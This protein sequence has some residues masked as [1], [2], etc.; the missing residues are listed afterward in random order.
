MTAENVDLRTLR[1]LQAPVLST[2]LKMAAPNL[3][4][5]L[6]QN[7]V[8][9][10]ELH[11]IGQ[12]GSE[13]LAGV[14]LVLP[15][16]ILMQNASSGAMGGGVASAVA[17]ALGA[18]RREDA[19]HYVLH[20]LLIG[21][22]F[23][24]ICAAAFLVGGRALYGA[25]GGHG[26]ALV[27]ACQYSAVVFSGAVLVW[28]FNALAGSLRGS[29]DMVTPALVAGVG[30]ILIIPVAA[31]LILGWGPVRSLGVI[32]GG[33]AMLAYYAV[34]IGVFLLRLSSGAAPVRFLVR[35]VKLRRAMFGDILRVGAASVMVPL[36]TA[37]TVGVVTWLVSP[38]GTAAIAGYGAGARL[39]YLVISITFALG[40]PLVT[41]VGTSVGAGDMARAYR[42]AAIGGGLAFAVAETMGL[43][44]AIFPQVWLGLFGSDPQLLATGTTYLRCVGPF[45]GFF[46]VGLALFFASQGPGRVL[47]PLLAGFVRLVVAGFGAGW[48]LHTFASL[49]LAFLAVGVGFL[50]Y[51]L[52]NVG[53][54]MT[55]SWAPRSKGR[56]PANATGH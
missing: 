1:L 38:L 54:V 35:H 10:T 46:G 26:P 28:G 2:L 27:S 18:G 3:V 22:L 55:G 11:F 19:S 14:S 25:M 34:G 17:R 12:L 45:L 51:G 52:I 33:L 48:A 21:L 43:W 42:V 37:L 47:W 41:L 13:A 8:A 31:A 39:E 20:G 40:A 29:G 23:G 5:I 49:S 16:Y 24:A 15:G 6:S 30:A 9:I 7:A 44:G 36:Q 4:V 56:P 53:A 50:A 32:G